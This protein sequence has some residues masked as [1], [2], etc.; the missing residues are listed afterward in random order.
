MIWSQIRMPEMNLRT[1]LDTETVH[2]I[3]SFLQSDKKL[4]L[5]VF[6]LLGNF[7][8]VSWRSSG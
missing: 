8:D 5:Q 2:I 7:L 6:F 4:L 3:F 1:I